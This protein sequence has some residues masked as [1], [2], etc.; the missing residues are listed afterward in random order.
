[1]LLYAIRC[2]LCQDETVL[3]FQAEVIP[4]RAPGITYKDM[5][6]LSYAGIFMWFALIE[7]FTPVPE[8]AALMSIGYVSAHGQ[9]NIYIAA[10]FCLAGLLV[11]DSLLFYASLKGTLIIGRL[12]EKVDSRLLE[13]LKLN[14]KKNAEKSMIIAALLP[15]VRFLSPVIAA[16]SGVPW[17]RFVLVNGL[18]TACYVAFYLFAGMFFYRKVTVLMA[19]MNWPSH[20]LFIAFVVLILIGSLIAIR[21]LVFKKLP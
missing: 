20:L 7:Q 2:H 11:A 9:L 18:V 12:L 8:E 14:F 10:V 13:N 6:Q 21:K 4:G 5:D 15:K 19:E 17:R 1:M 16:Y 3:A